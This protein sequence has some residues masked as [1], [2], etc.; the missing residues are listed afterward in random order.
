M[1]FHLVKTCMKYNLSA[2][3]LN[4]RQSLLNKYKLIKSYH[5]HYLFFVV[6]DIFEKNKDSPLKCGLGLKQCVCHDLNLPILIYYDKK[7]FQKNFQ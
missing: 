1:L 4:P 2:F 5:F 6:S 7:D 3:P